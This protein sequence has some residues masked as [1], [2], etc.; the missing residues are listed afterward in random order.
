MTS[1]P[2]QTVINALLDTERPF[3]RRYLAE[4]S[5]LDPE[6]LALLMQAW[7]RVAL[8]RKR[9]L[10]D[11][12]DALLSED[13]LVS[14]DVFARALLNDPDAFVRA[15]ALRL[16]SECDDV[17]LL[18][19]YENILAHDPSP[20]ARAEAAQAMNI[21]VELGELEEIPVAL[22][23]R[24]EEALLAAMGDDFPEVR[25]RALESLG[26]SS[27]PEVPPL[28]QA[29]LDEDDPDWQASALIAIG[30]SFDPEQ[31]GEEVLRFLLSDDSLVRLE[32]VRAAGNLMLAEARRPLL[33]M[34]E[35]E[36][37]G[38]ILAAIVWSLSQIGG[39]DVREYLENLLDQTD[40]EEEMAFLEDA[41][42][43][44]A[45]TEDMGRFDLMAYDLDVE[46]DE[47]NRESSPSRK[48]KKKGNA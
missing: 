29:A 1:I 17:S 40:D 21:F 27:R 37:D 35:E 22:H 28:I 32:A 30:R 2:F 14:F 9:A 6:S 38:D 33:Q 46:P 47:D 43:N 13:S 41:L 8:Q 15:G 24:A 18:P 34:L 31:W 26:Y 5:D 45:F 42:D 25:R 44:L 23:R 36:E 10:L 12:L 20:Q 16:L 4:F 48:S 3:P 7:P 11:D 19:V 39:E